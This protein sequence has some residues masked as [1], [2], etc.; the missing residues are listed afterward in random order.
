MR[1]LGKPRNAGPRWSGGLGLG[2]NQPGSGGA[3]GAG[4][5]SQPP[6][7]GRSL[8]P[9]SRAG[10][11]L[12]CCAPCRTSAWP[13]PG[14]RQCPARCVPRCPCAAGRQRDGMGAMGGAVKGEQGGRT[15]GGPA[16]DRLGVAPRRAGAA[17]GAAKAAAVCVCVRACV[18]ARARVCAGVCAVRAWMTRWSS[19][20]L[21]LARS[22]MS[23]ST[24]P[25]VTKLRR[26]EAGRVDGNGT[27]GMTR[28]ACQGAGRKM[29]HGAPGCLP[30]LLPA[31]RAE[32]TAATPPA[33]LLPS[34]K[35]KNPQA[36]GLPLAFNNSSTA[37]QALQR[38]R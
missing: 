30:R 38:C 18:C 14:R 23:S 36:G 16:S 8:P 22:R 10:V 6:V 5:G 24:L 2:S 34:R 37:L 28:A 9:G 20:I 12:R 29:A 31:S 13:A 17:G 35:A 11:V 7:A 25:L 19:T 1:G 26:R 33:A 4:A 15:A 3:P 21:R 32:G 27:R